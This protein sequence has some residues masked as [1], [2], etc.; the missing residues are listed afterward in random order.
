MDFAVDFLFAKVAI[1]R[2]LESAVLLMRKDLAS[3]LIGTLWRL[4]MR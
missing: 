1:Q 3:I 4:E 2:R